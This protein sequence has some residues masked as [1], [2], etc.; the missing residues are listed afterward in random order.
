[1]SNKYPEKGVT[2]IAL[3]DDILPS[4]D[5]SFSVITLFN[6]VL[7]E[8]KSVRVE[9]GQVYMT[10]NVMQMKLTVIKKRQNMK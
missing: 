3:I 4:S 5:I 6:V 1:M 8:L 9:E 10:P 7:G 2:I